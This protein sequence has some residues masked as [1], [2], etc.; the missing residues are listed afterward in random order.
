MQ[1]LQGPKIR[2]G[3]L[4]EAVE[5][6]TGDEITFST[7]EGEGIHVPYP[8]LPELVKTGDRILIN[9]GLIQCRVVST[10]ENNVH[11]KVEDGG[12][13]SSKKGLNIPD[14]ELPTDAKLS[15]KDLRDLKFGVQELEVD[16]VA[17]SFVENAKTFITCV[18]K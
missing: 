18:K 9:D 2:I 1:D 14:S 12:T 5:V 11:V 16:V 3:K 7:V 10:S 15:K 13:I 8:P 6:E 17:L 4:A